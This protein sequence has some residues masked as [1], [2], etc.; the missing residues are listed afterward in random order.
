VVVSRKVVVSMEV[1]SEIVCLKKS[2]DFD[3]SIRVICTN[4]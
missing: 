3:G 4:N 1:V 2:V